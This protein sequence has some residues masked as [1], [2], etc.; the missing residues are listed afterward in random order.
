[1]SSLLDAYT[2]ALEQELRASVV[3]TEAVEPLY[4]MMR[5]HL[6][7]IDTEG[8]PVSAPTGKRVRPAICLA[9]CEGYGANAAVALPAAAAIELLHNFTLIHDDIQDRSDERRHRTTVWK[10]WGEAQGITA[11]DAMH[12]IARLALLRTAALGVGVERVLA[13]AKLL[14]ET[15]L[16]ICEGQYLDIDFE[17][18]TEVTRTEYMVMIARKTAALV[19][20]SA[21]MGALLAGAG[22]EE[23]AKMWAFGN[24]LG[25][26]YQVQDD[27]LGIWGDPAVTGKPAA[28]DIRA[29]KKTLPVIHVLEQAGSAERDR[30]LAIFARDALTEDDVQEALRLLD[31]AGARGFAEREA[32]RLYEET[33]RHL[34]ST[35]ASAECQAAL[36]SLV[37]TLLLRPS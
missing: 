33:L 4:Q 28:D 14:D 21:K 1:M 26:A 20:C 25:L 16:R 24:N 3:D 2:P 29:K 34:A 30:L 5:Y 12:C 18:R 10:V 6:G 17:R 32:S 13:A 35:A 7:W 37:E 23:Q 36:S 8:R 19:A 22:E 9:V 27:I 15:C 11:G 31:A